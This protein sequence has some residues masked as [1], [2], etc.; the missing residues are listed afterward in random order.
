MARKKLKSTGM[1]LHDFLVYGRAQLL[2]QAQGLVNT[3]EKVKVCWTWDGN[4]YVLLENGEQDSRMLIKS[5]Y[6]L[7]EIAKKFITQKDSADKL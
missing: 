1:G 4:V 3:Y 5:V 7:K 2:R 6:D